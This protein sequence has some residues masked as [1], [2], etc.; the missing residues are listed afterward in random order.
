MFG[1]P[2]D[3]TIEVMNNLLTAPD[4]ES[5]YPFMED[6]VHDL[7]LIDFGHFNSKKAGVTWYAD[8]LVAASTNAKHPPGSYMRKSFQIQK[9]VPNFPDFAKRE[10]TRARAFVGG[11]IHGQKL[12]LPLEFAAKFNVQP[13]QY[14]QANAQGQPV[15]SI[16]K[17][18]MET[19][20]L[21]TMY[22]LGATDT[23]PARGIC[24]RATASR[25]KPKDGAPADSG[26]VNVDSWDTVPG[27][28]GEGIVGWRAKIDALVGPPGAR[29]AARQNRPQVPHAATQPTAYPQQ[30]AQTP[31]TAGFGAPAPAPLACR[32]IFRMSS[33]ATCDGLGV[34]SLPTISTIK[35]GI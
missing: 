10:Q 29:E 25:S 18:V 26:F 16:D 12:T 7:V 24:V 8:F 20:A 31:P 2:V 4:E 27:Q 6:G 34:P 5:R 33:F 23:Q 30:A 17:S 32:T 13:S 35:A 9:Q 19:T 1:Q 22:L 15:L 21:A 3:P 28:T 11:L 14:V